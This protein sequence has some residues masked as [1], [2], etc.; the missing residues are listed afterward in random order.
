MKKFLLQLLAPLNIIL[1][2]YFVKQRYILFCGGDTTYNAPDPINP[3]EEAAKYLFGSDVN[4]DEGFA[5]I[6][7]PQ[8]QGRLI[9]AESLYRPQYT[10]LQLKDV[11][12]QLQG[13]PGGM[14]SP[15]Y[16]AA[17]AKK[18]G[19]EAK[20]AA[21]ESGTQETAITDDEIDSLARQIM[22][23]R[24]TGSRQSDLQAAW[25]KNL[26]L[27][28]SQFSSGL[29]SDKVLA[30]I[31]AELAA[32]EGEL[33]RLAEASPV[34]G[35]MDLVDEAQQRAATQV[36]DAATKQREADIADITNLGKATV[37]ALRDADPDSA[38]AAERSATLAQ[39]LAARGT[40]PSAERDR[41]G[42]LAQQSQARISELE[43]LPAAD[44]STA[45]ADELANLKS[46][47]DQI[48]SRVSDLSKLSQSSF[49][50]DDPSAL[51][52][53]QAE[54]DRAQQVRTGLETLAGEDLLAQNQ[55]FDQARDLAGEARTIARRMYGETRGLSGLES[56]REAYAKYV[57]PEM[58]QL[59]QRAQG[60]QGQAADQ[61]MLGLRDQAGTQALSDAAAGIRGIGTENL[62]DRRTSLDRGIDTARGIADLG[63][64]T[65]GQ[66]AVRD[67]LVNIGVNPDSVSAEQQQAILTE[68]QGLSGRGRDLYSADTT[69]SLR[70]MRAQASEPRQIGL[71]QIERGQTLAGQAAG[72]GFDP[73]GSI[74]R[75]RAQADQISA[76]ADQLAQDAQGPL[77]AERRR[78]AEQSARQAGLRTGRIGDQAGL[79]AELLNREESRAALRQEAMD[80]ADRAVRLQSV[81]SDRALSA[82]EQAR[83]D[84]LAME[85][86]GL[87]AL[88]QSFTQ[89]TGLEQSIVDADQARRQQAA[90]IEL[91]ALQAQRQMTGDIESQDLARQQAAAS[92]ALQR[93]QQRAAL[94]NQ[95]VA[96]GLDAATASSQAEAAMLAQRT[97]LEATINQQQ[98]AQQQAAL[99]GETTAAQLG[100]EQAAQAE[101]MI[102][103][104]QRALR[105]EERGALA[106]V[107]D[108][109]AQ[110]QRDALSALQSAGTQQQLVQQAVLD[111]ERA[112]RGEVA[113]ESARIAAQT[114]AILTAEQRQQ[115]ATQAAQEQARQDELAFRTTETGMTQAALTAQQ[116][117][118]QAELDEARRR[119]AEIGAQEATAFAQTGQLAQM[120]AAQEQNLINQQLSA[121]QA[122]LAAQRAVGGDP[123]NV[124]LGRTGQ[125]AVQQGNVM[126]GQG[127]QQAAAGFQ[128]LFDPNVGINLGMQNFANQTQLAGQ[129][130][131]ADATASAGRSSMVGNLLGTIATC[132]V[133]REVYGESNP[134]WLH[135]REWLLNKAPVWFKNLYIKYGER[136]A[137]FISNKPMLKSI[138]KRWMN[139]RI[140]KC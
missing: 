81:F 61:A 77:S 73:T 74:F 33:T 106:D 139:T 8:F 103:D 60:L 26:E 65:T 126:V 75:G 46:Q 105:E 3:T 56:D 131:V 117:A 21:L 35:M 133:A 134:K 23:T 15:A 42:Q 67:A 127:Q 45:Q 112:R 89:R 122:D 108:R 30:D 136:F 71:G 25:D 90:D 87:G 5:G 64:V 118:A 98:L 82:Q 24:P 114:Q 10:A 31:D 52:D 47:R 93:E 19:L 121:N 41:L 48:S 55:R 111:E 17:L 62:E 140:A 39:E 54:R 86:A 99:A 58:Q 13:I 130:A 28:K 97:G 6:T 59:A 104:E 91:S 101:R 14:D 79:A 50:L 57:R 128:P 113:D 22:G 119:R 109:Q 7:D 116:Q 84:A 11:V 51:A 32:M 135:F 100:F 107:L 18:A 72:Q 95:L 123:A 132:W 94:E 63:G 92:T 1:F 4:F 120:D 34:P 29:G 80:A 36:R 115:A 40:D 88:G 110:G 66:Q 44:L 78:M 137:K 138:I 69:Q 125:A 76:M 85:Q 53:L 9:E 129:Q 2:N 20:K 12:S 49:R 124:I 16:I 68:L 102:A 37:E 83:R 38:A 96:Q 70:N 43:A 27:L